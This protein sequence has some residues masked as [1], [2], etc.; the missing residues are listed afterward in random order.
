MDKKK[1]L[2]TGKDI[3]FMK[4]AL[5][6]AEKAKGMTSPNPIVGAVLVKNGKIVAEDYHKKSG[7]PH[8]EVLAILKADRKA[9][10]CTLYVTLEPC[11]HTDKK[12]PPCCP[13]IVI[14]GIRKV[15]IAMRD[16]NPKVSGKGIKM[17]REHGVIVVEGVLE[18]KAKKLNEV[19]CKHIAT[20]RPFVTLKA[21]MTLD[22]KIATPE[23]ESKWITG[24]AARKIVHRMRCSSD[25]V[26]TAIGT[27]KADNP[28]LTSRVKCSKQPVR[29]IVDPAL[30]T[31]LDYKVTNIPP[32]TIFVTRKGENEKKSALQARGVQLVEFDGEKADLPWL[33]D[34][35]GSLGITSVLIEA[36]S[37]FN[38]SALQAGIV[39]KVIFFIAPKIICGKTSIPVVG[40]DF[41]MKLTEAIA[42]SDISVRKVGADIMVEGYIRR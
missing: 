31:P 27:I 25:A 4:R 12:T 34:R 2:I 24:E 40:G 41:F 15:V 18:D 42:L 19:Y 13:S 6:L 3:F 36:G 37:S 39:D 30:E 16:P 1:S 20:R 10:D 32:E 7:E 29:I 22:G 33:M 35:L 23:G 11:C 38:A 8:A 21:A 28:E 17:L 9:K 14:A 26:M 5:R